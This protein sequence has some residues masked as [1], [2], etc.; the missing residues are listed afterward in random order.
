MPKQAIDIDTDAVSTLLGGLWRRT[1]ASG[2]D[3]GGSTFV[4]SEEKT[5]GDVIILKSERT[6]TEARPVFVP[7]IG[8]MYLYSYLSD[9]AFPGLRRF[10][11]DYRDV[12]VVRYRPGKRVVLSAW[13]PEYGEVMIKTIARGIVGVVARMN[14][15]W[16]V[17]ADLEFAVAKPVAW[18]WAINTVVQQRLPGKPLALHSPDIDPG[19]VSKLASAIRSLHE[20]DA[21]FP[22]QFGTAEQQCRSHRYARIIK[23]CVAGSRSAVNNVLVRLDQLEEKM[24][25]NPDEYR[26]L[27]GSLHSKQW[28]IDGHRLA[29]VD[30]DR[31]AMGHPE[32]D[33]ATLIAEFDYEPD[34]WGRTVNESFLDAFMPCDLGTLLYYRVHKHLAKAFKASKSPDPVNAHAKTHRNLRRALALDPHTRGRIT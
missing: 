21:R 1:Y 10:L 12:H 4:F 7:G 16:Q 18:S 24:A 22:Q 29:L 6:C 13:H 33:A 27:H 11:S 31:A 2:H 20:C 8:R 19:Q 26:P 23:R 5:A 17:R 32:L 15:V 9:P 3:R 28:L 34:P 14:A 25:K 30:F